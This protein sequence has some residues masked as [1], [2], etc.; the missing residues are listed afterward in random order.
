M[1]PRSLRSPTA[2]ELLSI[3][4]LGVLAVLAAAV[5]VALV[6]LVAIPPDDLAA[7]EIIDDARAL[8][9]ALERYASTRA[10]RDDQL[11]F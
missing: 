3:P 10:V 1:T 11:P 8:A 4:E 5:D 7:K 2:E 9:A 6:A